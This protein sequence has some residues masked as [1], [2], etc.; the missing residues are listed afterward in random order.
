MR[1]SI[2]SNLLFFLLALLISLPVIAPFFHPGYFPTHDG[3]WAVVRLTDMFREIKDFQIP[4]RF[5][6]NLNFG[7][8]YPLF[9]FAYP[10]PYYLGFVFN[11]FH[12]G[13]VNSIKILFALSVPLSAFAMF[14]LSRSVWKSMAASLVSMTLY[15]YLPY[16]F[17]DLYVRGSLGESLIFVFYPLLFYLIWKIKEK[18]SSFLYILLT[19]FTYAF[20]IMTH[21][22]MAFYSIILLGG[23]LAAFLFIGLR[24]AF[25]SAL[26]SVTGGI[27]L[28]AFF[29]IPAL[30]EKKLILLSKIPIADRSLYFVNLSQLLFPKWGYGTPTDMDGFSY[31]IGWPHLLLFLFVIGSV[32]FVFLKKKTNI[33][34]ET[35]V[36]LLLFLLLSLFFLLSM[37]QFSSFIWKLPGFS[38]INYPWTMLLPLGF[39]VS[40]LAGYLCTLNKW[41]KYITL[42][43]AFSAVIVFLPYAKPQSF[44]DRGDSFYLTND[45]T[46]TSSDELMPLWVKSKPV[47]RY[48][49]KVEMVKGG[50]KI[51]VI[52]TNSKETAFRANL[53]EDSHIRI[54]TIYYPGWQVSVGGEPVAISYANAKGLMDISLPKGVHTVRAEFFETPVRLFSD[55]V[56]LTTLVIFGVFGI[57]LLL[58]RKSR[59]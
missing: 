48:V 42:I 49:E 55:L 54:N 35:T 5:S 13:L 21:N 47:E 57:V 4:P 52:M 31:Q 6:G 43:C 27:L 59:T 1:K 38:E 24:K 45:A 16:R 10:F 8:G 25:I 12:F 11:S 20:L 53:N 50:G 17:V 51:S 26:L 7:Y 41:T 28:S 40:L 3:E 37:F 30:L 56:S 32:L 29:W 44:V 39:L 46:T 34:K 36:F 18:P 23:V 58:R 9:N 2:Y 19:S 15:I 14:L 33:E 22:I